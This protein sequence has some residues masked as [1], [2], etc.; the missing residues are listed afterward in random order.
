MFI[1]GL[2]ASRIRGLFKEAK[3]RAPCIIYIDEIDAIGRKRSEG[4]GGNMGGGG[5]S[6][7]LCIYGLSIDNVCSHEKKCEKQILSQENNKF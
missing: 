6:E 1:I 7:V 3:Q 4:K 5:S 2:G